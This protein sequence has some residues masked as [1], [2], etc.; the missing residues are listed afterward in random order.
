MVAYTERSSDFE[1]DLS[2]T[3]ILASSIAKATPGDLDR[4]RLLSLMVR[5]LIASTH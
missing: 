1:D 2:V 5:W 3:T 4:M